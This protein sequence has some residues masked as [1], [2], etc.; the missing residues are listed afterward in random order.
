MRSAALRAVLPWALALF[1]S[2]PGPAAEP[3]AHVVVQPVVN[4]H[5]KPSA[6]AE[7]V[8]Q[9]LLGARLVELERDGGWARITAEDDYL[10]WVPLSALRTLEGAERYPASL[11]A[12]KVVEV[13][14]L[15][16]NIFAE[17][18]VTR[19]APL[20]TAPFGV[21]L[22]R[23]PSPKDSKRWLQIRLPDRRSAWIQSGDVRTDLRPLS[24]DASLQLARRFLGVNYTW[25][26]TSSFG[27]DC[28]GFTQTIVR[29][30]GVL[31]PRDARVQAAWSGLVEVADRADLRPGDLLFFRE[32]S[33]AISHTGIYLGEG[34]FIHDSTSQRPCVQISELAEPGWSKSLVA[35]RRLK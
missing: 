21:R 25:G 30:R 3:P 1:M 32:T 19:R 28:S 18:T 33:P 10:G 8:S 24:L 20:L 9:A 14:A 13:D 2:M 34:R 17:P 6:E 7:V 35:M 22:E 27:F 29:S 15:A 16:A 11:E 5:G 31:M 12:G 26:G 23:D 4:L